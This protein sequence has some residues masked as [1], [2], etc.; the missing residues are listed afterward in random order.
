MK[1]IFE[2]VCLLFFLCSVHRIKIIHIFVSINTHSTRDCSNLILCTIFLA[3]FF[4]LNALQFNNGIIKIETYATLVHTLHFH[5]FFYRFLF[6]F[7]LF[8]K[9]KFYSIFPIHSRFNNLFILFLLL[10]LFVPFTMTQFSF[11]CVCLFCVRSVLVSL[12]AH[13]DGSM[14]WS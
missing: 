3:Y 14:K 6:C 7:V 5:L 4:L 2:S 12:I 9:L 13:F 10:L 11:V 8:Y 1:S